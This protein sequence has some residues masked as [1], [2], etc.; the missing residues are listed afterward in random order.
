MSEKGH[1]V[2][3][4][5]VLPPAL[6]QHVGELVAS[7]VMSRAAA[8]QPL[9]DKAGECI[10]DSDEQDAAAVSLMKMMNDA[11]K[12]TDEERAAFV[13]PYND[14]VRATNAAF[15][16]GLLDGLELAKT[17]VKK[18][19]D[20]YARRKVER[21]RQEQELLQR[22][23]ARLAAERKKALEDDA[24]E[25]AGRLRDEGHAD[26]ADR[27]LNAAVNV[28]EMVSQVAVVPEKH[29]GVTKGVVGGSGSIRK[30]W[31]WRL[32]PTKDPEAAV[33]MIPKEFL[34]PPEQ[35]VNAKI[36]RAAISGKA[37]RR[38]VPG[39]EIYEEVSSIVR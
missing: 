39:L 33:S 2:P 7:T 34:I 38:N 12:S 6:S 8:L 24:I 21:A 15:N 1:L 29:S 31:V 37:G 3:T 11:I 18:E 9:L 17:K 4:E 22:E 23:E 20:Q 27:L 30:V 10:I 14:L 32:D 26:E 25:K 5:T 36:V 28:S 13:R 35:R 16:G 19:L